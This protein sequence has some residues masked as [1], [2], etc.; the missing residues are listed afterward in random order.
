MHDPS[1]RTA[2]FWLKLNAASSAACGLAC[3]LAAA[4]LAAL[5]LS[6][7]PDWTAPALRMLGAG[8]LI[9]AGL[10]AHTGLRPVPPAA[11]VQAISAAD[12][13]WVLGSL[14]LIAAAPGAFT[15]AGFWVTLTVAAGVAAFGLGQVHG[16]RRMTARPGAKGA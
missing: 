14:A 7:P 8:L 10:V 9:F 5:L 6:A 11:H 4:P 2:R 3:L 12:A 13:L 15:A 1:P 16:V